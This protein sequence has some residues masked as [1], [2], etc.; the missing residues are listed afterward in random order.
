MTAAIIKDESRRAVERT[1]GK[2]LLAAM[3]LQGIDVATMAEALDMTEV[4]MSRAL[5]GSSSLSAAEIYWAAKVLDVPVAQL[6]P[7]A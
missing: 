2:R 3:N 7:S 6:M 5:K 1:I 4:R